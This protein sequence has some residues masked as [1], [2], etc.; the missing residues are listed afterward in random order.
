[1]L[2]LKR[3]R[4]APED[5]GRVGDSVARVSRVVLDGGQREVDVDLVAREEPLEIRVNAVAIAVVMRTPG[6]DEELTL[7][8]LCT[9]G[10]VR[11]R[12]D[13]V[14]VEHCAGASNNN[15]INVVLSPDCHVD[16]NAMRRNT[17]ASSSCGLCGKTTI[18]RAM[19]S[20]G[21][22]GPSLHG[23]ISGEILSSL[24]ARL[25]HE[26]QVFA[27]T[28]GL[29]AMG[30]FRVTG[31]CTVVR[32]D[33]GRHNAADKVIGW[34]VERG[35]DLSEQIMMA[36]GRLSCEVVQKAWAAQI[37]VVAG[38]SA[39]TSLAIEMAESA[40]ITL[41]GFLRGTRMSIY[42]EPARVMGAEASRGS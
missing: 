36:S 26:Q 1:M 42:T 33:V 29:H 38:I 31:E 23:A 10:V 20:W 30:L 22:I 2:P 32:E 8:F 24:P 14:S 13:V 3:R 27:K 5:V 21:R 17:Y 19:Q 18:D 25:E 6:Q 12:S 39:P 9:E 11:Q 16:L 4:E 41:I 34:A 40:G 15:I 7:G 35:V 28:G 37:P